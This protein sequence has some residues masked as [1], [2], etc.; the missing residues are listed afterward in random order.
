F[1][2]AM[3][4]LAKPAAYLLNLAN[5]RNLV[6]FPLL[7]VIAISI[8]ALFIASFYVTVYLFKRKDL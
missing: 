6:G 1:L 5:E 3:I 7:L 2:I 8:L 4:V